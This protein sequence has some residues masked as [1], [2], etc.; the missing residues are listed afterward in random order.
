VEG[1]ASNDPRGGINLMMERGYACD[2]DV[3]AGPVPARDMIPISSRLPLPLNFGGFITHYA[4]LTP[5]WLFGHM[6]VHFD[7]DHSA[8]Q[9]EDVGF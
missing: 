7:N 3:V 2:H 9:R 4:F 6:T 1:W 5:N 8:D